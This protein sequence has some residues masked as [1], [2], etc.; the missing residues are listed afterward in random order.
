LRV[1][2]RGAA[3]ALRALNIE[4]RTRCA[5]ARTRAHARARARTPTHLSGS[6]FSACL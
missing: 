5:S 3:R 6:I 4:H 1:A 2:Y